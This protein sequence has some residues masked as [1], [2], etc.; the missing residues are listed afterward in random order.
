M[1]KTIAKFEDFL[2]YSDAQINY[3]VNCSEKHRFVYV[4][5][6]KVACSTIKKVLQLIE[7]DGDQERLAVN[8][9]DRVKSPLAA[10]LKMDVDPGILLNSDEYFRFAFV[11]N[12]FTRVL[13]AYL[14]KLVKNKWER[15]RLLPS[16]G[17]AKDAQISLLQFLEAIREIPHIH[18]DIH[19]TPQ[20]YLLQPLKIR[21][22]FI[23]RFEN[24]NTDFIMVI[25]KIKHDASDDLLK[26]RA[27]QHKTNASG[28]VRDY[29]GKK[30]RDLIIEIFEHDFKLFCYCKDPHFANA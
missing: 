4:E 16:L 22:H 1:S 17:F 10:P 23:G 9:H 2:P 13:S 18:K 8:V 14:D 30:E 28:K 24:F 5:T 27:D 6:P 25:K 15:E 7:M 11:R 19:W 21:Y 20:S 12:P 26:I 29:I 3:L